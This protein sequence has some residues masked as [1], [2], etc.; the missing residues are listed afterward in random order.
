MAKHDKLT[1]PIAKSVKNND[2]YILKYSST[3]RGKV[4]DVTVLDLDNNPY[5]L[6][7]LS[8]VFVEELYNNQVIV[9]DGTESNSGS[10][11]NTDLENGKFSYQF[12]K[13]VYQYDGWAHFK[14]TKNENTI[15]TTAGFAIRITTDIDE[16][17]D[18][19]SYIAYFEKLKEEHQ[20][21][22]NKAQELLTQ[23]QEL[24]DDNHSK[25]A[26]LNKS[27]NDL[28]Q[29]H[30]E[31][32]KT[33]NNLSKTVTDNQKSLTDQIKGLTDKNNQLKDQIDGL[34][35]DKNTLTQQVSDLTTAKNTLTEDV[36][37]LKNSNQELSDKNN[38]L[39]QQVTKLTP[40][41]VANE[42]DVANQDSYFVIVDD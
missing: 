26:V 35:S 16:D 17:L 39:Q 5:D 33:V 31:L 32:E 20:T 4:I 29:N 2:F 7:G 6:T 34:I 8:I 42:S 28:Q 10:F 13:D 25:V 38:Q 36:N 23:A 14:F 37:R 27:F 1:L 9:D 15:D 30:N 22:L 18:T 24:N 19:K 12:Q 21:W 40:V 41:H 3:E 11:V